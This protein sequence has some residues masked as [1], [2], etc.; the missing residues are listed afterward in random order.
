MILQQ[1]IGLAWQN[2]MAGKK[3]EIAM[4]R[5]IKNRIANIITATALL[6]ALVLPISVC[7]EPAEAA[8]TTSS[9]YAEKMQAYAYGDSAYAKYYPTDFDN[10]IPSSDG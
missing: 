5:D 7:T 4:R 3:E 6:M 1:F 9:S 2:L 10:L 8:V